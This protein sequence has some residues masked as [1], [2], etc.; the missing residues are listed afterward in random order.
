MDDIFETDATPAF[1]TVP[2]PDFTS[3]HFKSIRISFPYTQEAKRF[4]LS[5][6]VDLRSTL[7][8]YI[9]PLQCK[10]SQ[11]F[12]DYFSKR[13]QRER[14]QDLTNQIYTY[15]IEDIKRKK[16]DANPYTMLKMPIPGY[17]YK[18]IC[19]MANI[20]KLFP[21]ILEKNFML[22]N[23]QFLVLGDQGGFSEFIVNQ[24][25]SKYF[26]EPA[27]FALFPKILFKVS[28][29]NLYP[30]GEIAFATIK[31]V[32]EDI[33]GNEGESPLML[34]VN[35]LSWKESDSDLEEKYMN[36]YLT[37]SIY[38]SVKLLAKG[39]NLVVKLYNT[40]QPATVEL[41]YIVSSLFR[42]VS[43]FKPLNSAPHSAVSFK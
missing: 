26:E 36:L 41:I 34:V 43:L 1:S 17:I 42:S 30:D 29:V 33:E 20:L 8:D 28:G 4:S 6:E 5:G 2:R 14:I 40:Y 11:H 21:E 9:T 31:K 25:I 13:Y 37:Y 16:L 12:F 35:E 18:G 3:Q 7:E 24:Y 27:G 23:Y 32:A 38:L 22:P 15:P 10:P 39:G 19:R